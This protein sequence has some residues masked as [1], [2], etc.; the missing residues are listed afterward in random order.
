MQAEIVMVSELRKNN[1][2]LFPD[3]FFLEQIGARLGLD[4]GEIQK[5]EEEAKADAERQFQGLFTNGGLD[6]VV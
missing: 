1:P 5:L 6:G 4:A 2:G 3:S